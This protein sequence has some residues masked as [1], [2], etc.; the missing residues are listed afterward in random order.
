MRVFISAGEASGDAYGAALAS[1]MRRLSPIVD[2]AEFTG[3][4]RGSR[5]W[6]EAPDGPTPGESSLKIRRDFA[7]L[8]GYDLEDIVPR[9]FDEEELNRTPWSEV[10]DRLYDL[11]STSHRGRM[12]PNTYEGIGGR[13]MR[14]ADV[15]IV[16]DSGSWGAISIVQSLRVVPRV[17]RG[18]YRAKA[19][20]SAA[21][22]GLFIP[23]DFGYANIRLARHAKNRGW[24]VLYFVPPGSWRRDRQG[25]DLPA[26]TDAISTPFSWS[27][28][29][30]QKMGA[31]AHWFGHPIKQL[32]RDS[33]S[34]THVPRET[35]AVLPGSR[36][37]EIA[38][39]LP[40]IAEVMRAGDYGPVEFG[41]APTVDGGKFRA[42]W[43]RLVPDRS[44]DV[45]TQ[46]DTA[47]VLRRGRAAIVC[48]G[49]ATLEA[50]LCRCPMV[51]VYRVSRAVVVEAKILRFK[52]PKFIALPNILMDRMLVP[53]LVQDEATPVTVRSA[54]DGILLEGEE[55]TAQLQGF[56]E[57]DRMLGPDDAIT[58]TAELALTLL[59]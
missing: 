15:D 47:G 51:V 23:I 52:R 31:N 35:I 36:E 14:A 21:P 45:F 27:A 39:N 29:L 7:E 13:R 26:L 28:E 41:L 56:D 49:T 24:K 46:S 3:R 9:D 42:D 32:L 18:Y 48:S 16:A 57:L 1:E 58:R 54:L 25:G 5:Y 12:T 43:E 33:A 38:E 4:V 22:P 53:E 55:R 19:Q 50:A 20:I 10:P 34:N 11:L 30:L 40:L 2:R 37:H 17:L 6:P 59:G 8:L 44:G